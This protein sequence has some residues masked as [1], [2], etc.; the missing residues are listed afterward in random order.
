MPWEEGDKTLGCMLEG[1]PEDSK[2]VWGLRWKGVWG[3]SQV[4]SPPKGPWPGWGEGTGVSPWCSVMGVGSFLPSPC[5]S[6]KARPL[7]ASG[8]QVLWPQASSP[9]YSSPPQVLGGE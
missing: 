4:C 2:R 5:A 3:D 6:E 7:K 8:R 9:V 1:S